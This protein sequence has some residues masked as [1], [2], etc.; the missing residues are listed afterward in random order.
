MQKA[1]AFQVVNVSGTVSFFSI[2]ALS[3]IES[4]VKSQVSGKNERSETFGASKEILVEA[5]L[6]GDG[7]LCGVGDLS[8]DSGSKASPSNTSGSKS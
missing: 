3:L 4:R 1:S 8:E 2:S 6:I 5:G 7:A